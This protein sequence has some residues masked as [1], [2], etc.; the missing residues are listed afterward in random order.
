MYLHVLQAS[1]PE[2][3]R[4]GAHLIAVTPQKPD[5]SAPQVKKDGYPFEV[6][7]DLDSKVMKAYRL[8]FEVDDESVAIYKNHGLGLTEY[9]DQGRNVLPVPG[10]FVIDTKGIVRAMH[11]DP[12]YTQR[13][14]P[15]D[16]VAALRQI[17]E[18]P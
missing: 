6:L 5:K 8:Y 4:Y 15:S 16:I 11:A 14:E 1:L 3:E 10:T 7:S 12:D 17:T 13:M 9:N 18:R 2:F